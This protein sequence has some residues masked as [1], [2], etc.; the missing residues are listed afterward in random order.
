MCEKYRT[1]STRPEAG[2]NVV[3]PSSPDARMVLDFPADQVSIERPQGSDSLF[4]RFDDGSS[5]ELQSFYTQYNKDAI[6]SF[7]VDGQLIAGADFFNAFG[8]DLAPAAG[9]AASPTRGG[10]Y[11]DYT[12]AGLED[13]VN[14]LDG[15]DY[16]LG[17]GGVTDETLD[18][19][20]SVPNFAPVLSTGGA[21]INMGITEAGVGQPH[22]APITGSFSAHD[23][24]GD[25]LTARVNIGGKSVPISGVTTIESDFGKLIITP[26]GGGG[27]V[28]YNFSY[29]LN[30]TPYGHAD[31]LAKGET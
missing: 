4:F 27:D 22:M 12:N 29:E 30:D 5:I 18:T 1:L 23:P 6:P 24:D 10:R 26:V 19:Y 2:Q 31:S 11:T 17:F 3:V 13:G 8:P 9:P 25:S 15:L 16:R 28:T 20:A 21:S 14:H 7:E